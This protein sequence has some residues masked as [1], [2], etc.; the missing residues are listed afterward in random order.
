[1][2]KTKCRITKGD[3][4]LMITHDAFLSYATE[5]TEIASA[6]V[7]GLTSH[8]LMIW[9]APIELKVGDKLLDSIE[10]GMNESLCGV[11]LVSPAYLSKGWTSYEMDTFIRANIENNKKLLPV[12]HGVSKEQVAEKH[13]G[14]AGIVA[15]NTNVGIVSVVED[16]T[17]VL[18]DSAPTRGVIPS[19]ES[20]K[21]RFLRGR[22]EINLQSEDG[23]AT[24]LWEF[25]IHSQ[26]AAYPLFLEGELFTKE[27]LLLEAAQ[28]LLHIPDVIENAVGREGREKIYAMCKDAGVDPDMFA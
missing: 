22:G 17:G 3:A 18:S 9:Y 26:D 21:L 5:D 8:G 20:P 13:S 1:M 6:L 19:Y 24:T 2:A 10:R 25:L 4:G 12:W 28:L 27:D 23:P 11:L 7:Q 14:L 15:V 16:L